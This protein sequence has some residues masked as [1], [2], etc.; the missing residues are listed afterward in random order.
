MDLDM[1]NFYW[2]ILKTLK[3]DH[4]GPFTIYEKRKIIND[5][6]LLSIAVIKLRRKIGVGNRLKGISVRFWNRFMELVRFKNFFSIYSSDI[7]GLIQE[8]FQNRTG[9]PPLYLRL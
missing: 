2:E 4:F 5:K 6:K 9:F 1:E 7:S 8:R 3:R